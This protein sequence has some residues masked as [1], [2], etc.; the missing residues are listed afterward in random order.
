MTNLSR[1]SWDLPGLSAKALHTR[2][3]HLADYFC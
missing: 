3:F 2:C 1:F